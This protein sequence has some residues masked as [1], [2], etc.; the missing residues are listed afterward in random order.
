[1]GSSPRGRKELD[2][3]ERLSL[4]QSLGGGARGFWGLSLWRPAKNPPP[5]WSLGLGAPLLHPGPTCPGPTGSSPTLRELEGGGAQCI[6]GWHDLQPA[7]RCLTRGPGWH[8]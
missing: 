2:T 4:T 1:M 5:G 6:T 7:G 3:T 8:G